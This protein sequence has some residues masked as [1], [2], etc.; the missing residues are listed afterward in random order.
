MTI[1]CRFRPDFVDFTPPIRIPTSTAFKCATG[2]LDV[3]TFGSNP[4]KDEY[5]PRFADREGSRSPEHCA[6]GNCAPAELRTRGA[7][8]KFTYKRCAKRLKRAGPRCTE[9]CSSIRS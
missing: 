4:Q 1:V 3:M 2:L 5:A 9:P 6:H 8:R 7:M